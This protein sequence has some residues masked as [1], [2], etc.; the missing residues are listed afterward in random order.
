[1]ILKIIKKQGHGLLNYADNG[2]MTRY[3]FALKIA[4]I[5]EL[6]ANLIKQIKTKELK[7]E[8]KR[9]MKSGLITKKIENNF[10]I[11]PVSVNSSL[12]SLKKLVF[13]KKSCR[14]S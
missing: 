12:H 4:N 7:Q 3:D 13:E 8:A 11:K 14:I 1:M 5:F 10:N 9:P 2:L 6:D